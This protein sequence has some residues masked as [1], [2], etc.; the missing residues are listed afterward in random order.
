MRYM[1]N[2]PEAY[3]LIC[4]PQ[5]E[6]FESARLHDK[7]CF[8]NRVHVYRERWTRDEKLLEFVR[9][10]NESRVFNAHQARKDAL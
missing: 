3:D 10:V 2:Y 9:S 1:A 5:L 8:S 4:L 6:L 7:V